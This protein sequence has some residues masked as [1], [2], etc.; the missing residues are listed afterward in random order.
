[1]GVA[2]WII[3]AEVFRERG[4]GVKAGFGDQGVVAFGELVFGAWYCWCQVGQTRKK[5]NG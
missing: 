3:V 4:G 5:E 1:M 2:P